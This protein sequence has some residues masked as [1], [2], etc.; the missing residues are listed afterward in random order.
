MLCIRI[1]EL[2]WQ[3]NKDYAAAMAA[4]K[5]GREVLAGEDKKIQSL[6]NRR[7]NEKASFQI[8]FEEISGEIDKMEATVKAKAGK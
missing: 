2:E 3:V 1:A 5:E 6:G 7:P 4:I 8:M